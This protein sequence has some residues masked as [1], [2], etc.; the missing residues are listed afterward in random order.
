MAD[1][2]ISGLPAS[3]TPLA[4]TEVLPIVQGGQTRQVSVN[5]LTAGKAVTASSVTATNLKTSPATANLDISGI[6]VAATGSDAN[7]DVNIN[8]KG[9]GIAYLNQA[10]GVNQSGTLVPAANNTYD[11]GNGVNNPRD[12]GVARNIA[13]T[14]TGNR[15]T[16][17][18]TNATVANRAAFQTS[19]TN[20]GTNILAVPNGT[21]Q[22]S[23]FVATNAADPT[24]SSTAQIAVS[25]VETIFASGRF[26]S[27][28]F[29]PLVMYAGGSERV[30]LHTSGGVSIG[31]TTDPGAT[32]LSV[33]GTITSGLHTI[34]VASGN[35]LY[36]QRNAGANGYCY[37]DFAN[38]YTN[39]YSLDR[40]YVVSGGTNGVYLAPGGTSWTA[41]SD[42]RKKDIIE[43]ITNAA[44]KVSTLRAVIGK[45]KNEADDKRRSFLIAQD[46]QAVLPEA[47]D[48]T[49]PD[50]LGLSYSD[51]I[52]LLVAAITELKAEVDA[53]KGA[54]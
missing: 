27:G 36:L 53:L 28:S 3:T 5:N 52:P 40:Y 44:S 22:I 35:A 43:P 20:G 39:W 12:V 42:E 31:N 11:I 32:N 10:W 23:R 47:V 45:Y 2:K 51:V 38:A 16:A 4:G 17:D 7:I 14:G 19:T 13:F 9:S 21:S 49:D 25:D 18:F 37:V 33:T 50:T 24:N 54:K 30:R 26:G 8:A 46:V 15:I 48:A 34:D 1:V 41:V 29:L 6:T